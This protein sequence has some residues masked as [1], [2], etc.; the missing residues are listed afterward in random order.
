[1]LINAYLLTAVSLKQLRMAV[2][3]VFLSVMILHQYFL[4]KCEGHADHSKVLLISL[5][6]FRHDYLDLLKANGTTTP[7]FDILMDGGVTLEYLK[8]VFVTK[9]LPSHHSISTGLYPERHGVIGNRMFDPSVSETEP[10]YTGT[11]SQRRNPKWFYN[12][13]DGPCYNDKPWVGEPIWITNQRS[14]QSALFPRRSGTLYWI[15]SDAP[16]CDNLPFKYRETE[17]KHEDRL[18]YAERFR[19]IVQWFSDDRGPINLG[20]L[21]IEEPDHTAHETGVL[22]EQLKDK[23]LELDAA[24]GELI[25]ELN[26]SHLFSEMNVILTSDHGMTNIVKYVYLED[27]LDTSLIEYHGQ[28]PVFRVRPKEGK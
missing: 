10:L 7:N 4:W 5:D 23:I 26:K 27:L 22:S 15:G 16:V 17:E 21:Y 2:P 18:S 24:L 12:G 14:A 6:G 3:R 1:M 11:Y 8:G 13:T 9:T 20:L 25:K 19:Q 28:S